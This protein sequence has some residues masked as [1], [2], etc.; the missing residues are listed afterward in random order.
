MYVVYTQ[1]NHIDDVMLLSFHFELPKEVFNMT[2]KK[3]LVFIIV[4]LLSFHFELPKEVFNMT[5]KKIHVFIILH[6]TFSF[7]L[8]YG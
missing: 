1:K 2:D 4:M 7:L 8:T 5:D 3:I 6:T